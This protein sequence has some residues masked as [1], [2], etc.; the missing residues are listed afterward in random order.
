M[1]L[2]SKEQ[3]ELLMGLLLKV[4]FEITL[5]E[6]LKGLDPNIVALVKAIQEAEVEEK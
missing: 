3:R 4:P 2:D 1:K 6:A 5:A